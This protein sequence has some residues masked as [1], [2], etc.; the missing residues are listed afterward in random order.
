MFKTLRNR[1]IFSYTLIILLCLSLA[2]F[3]ALILIR[4]YQRELALVQRR[5]VASTVSQRLAFYA[6]QLH[7][8]ELFDRVQEEAVSLGVRLLVVSAEG[9]VLRDTEKEGSLEGAQIRIPIQKILDDRQRPLILPYTA[10]NGQDFFLV[11]APIRLFPQSDDQTPPTSQARFVM[12]A[13]PVRDI[14]PP[15]RE[16]ATPLIASGA[17]ALVVSTIVAFFLSNSITRPLAAITRATEAMARGDYQQS[18]SVAGED[19]IARLATGFNRMA[20]AVE[21]ARQSQR[22]FLANVSHDLRTPLTSISGFAQAILDGQ[23]SDTEGYIHAAAI[24]QE[25]AGR[26][27]DLVEELLDL[28]RLEAGN[29]KMARERLDLTALVRSSIEARTPQAVAAGVT[30]RAEGTGVPAVIGDESRLKQVFDNLLDNAIKYTPSGGTV[31]VSIRQDGKWVAVAVADTGRG[32][33][34]EDLP[35]IFERFYRADKSRGETVGAGLGLAIVKEIVSAHGGRI[36]VESEEGQGS[37]FTVF[38]PPA[39][40]PLPK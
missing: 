7:S 31:T 10:K 4:H 9:I 26:M 32:I 16:L 39:D 5:A 37:V 1:L 40:K 28:A 15:W 35:R 23:V 6:T 18:I 25:E 17:I 19:E 36:T 3:S 27:S 8:A 20:R 12:L 34:R 22:D 29:V 21:Q 38:L 13:V 14:Q 11:I 2:G 24:I 30:L 33:P